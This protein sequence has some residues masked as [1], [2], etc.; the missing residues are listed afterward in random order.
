VKKVGGA[1]SAQAAKDFAGG[2]GFAG[3]YSASNGTFQDTMA[4]CT[5]CEYTHKYSQLM[6]DLDKDCESLC[7]PQDDPTD[8]LKPSPRYKLTASA[9]AG[10]S[11]TRRTCR[12]RS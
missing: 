2:M 6:Q 1:G 10:A 7:F 9:T 5:R 11:S 4:Q 8:L 3:A 12:T